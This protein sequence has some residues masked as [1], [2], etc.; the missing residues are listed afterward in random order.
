MSRNKQLICTRTYK[1]I[2]N[3]EPTEIGP[4]NGE[5]V[6][7]LYEAANIQGVCGYRLKEYPGYCFPKS[8]FKTA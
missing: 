3:G 1:W 4:K 7:A 8:N 6:T 5:L 2:L